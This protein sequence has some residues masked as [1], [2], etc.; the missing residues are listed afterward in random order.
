[1]KL[2]HGCACEHGFPSDP[3]VDTYR[4]PP[5]DGGGGDEHAL[6]EVVSCPVA[7]RLPAASTASTASV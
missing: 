3:D 4:V 2:K 7:E 6:V 5:D 1:L